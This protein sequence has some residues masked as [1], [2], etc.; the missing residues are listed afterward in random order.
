MGRALGGDFETCGCTDA[1]R[2]GEGDGAAHEIDQP[3]A[4]GETE[5]GAAVLARDTSVGLGEGLEET[6]ER[7]GIDA[8]AGITDGEG[9]PGHW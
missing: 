7:F 6:L 4:D 2:A 9:E 1:G 5:T 3:F 8:D